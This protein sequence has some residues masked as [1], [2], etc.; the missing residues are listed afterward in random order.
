MDRKPTLKAV[1]GLLV[2]ECVSD[3]EDLNEE[4]VPDDLSRPFH[5]IHGKNLR[6]EVMT[7]SVRWRDLPSM[8]DMWHS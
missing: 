3:D 8:V 2:W 5:V 7:H 1:Y 4:V 6:K